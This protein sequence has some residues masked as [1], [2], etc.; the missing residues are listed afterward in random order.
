MQFNSGFYKIKNKA[1]ELFKLMNPFKEKPKDSEKTEY[2]L[3]E[4]FIKKHFL[5][6]EKNDFEIL[7]KR[8]KLLQ[9]DLSEVLARDKENILQTD[10][11]I[12]GGKIRIMLIC[13]SGNKYQ[14]FIN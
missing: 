14:F 11:E 8:Y 7:E 2:E 1:Q 6:I 4:R 10:Y 12:L 13:K 3:C 5:N 9:K